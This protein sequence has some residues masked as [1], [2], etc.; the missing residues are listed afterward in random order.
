MK[1]LSLQQDDVNARLEASV[2][3]EAAKVPEPTN[4]TN[5]VPTLGEESG[6]GLAKLDAGEKADETPV[7]EK[8]EAVAGAIGKEEE[9]TPDSTVVSAFPF[10]VALS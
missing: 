5:P 4:G 8:V 10:L 1:N 2:S 3:K 7:E 6:S 9:A